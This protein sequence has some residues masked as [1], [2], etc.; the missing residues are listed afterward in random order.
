MKVI[1]NDVIVTESTSRGTL[2]I[3]EFM[4]LLAHA[5]LESLEILIRVNTMFAKHVAAITA[6]PE[7]C[8]KYFDVTPSMVTAFLPRIGYEQCELILKEFEVADETNLRVFLKKKL[9]KD[10]VDKVLSPYNLMSLGHRESEK[11]G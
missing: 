7:K 8:Q 6:C 3:N 4:P 1:A 10:L 2:Q 9:G 5:I 11:N